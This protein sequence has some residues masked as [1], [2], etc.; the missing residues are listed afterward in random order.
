MLTDCLLQSVIPWVAGIGTLLR[1][2][3]YL[4]RFA[5]GSS[6]VLATLALPVAVHVQMQLYH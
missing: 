2:L 1:L 4:V 5:T 6:L 3:L